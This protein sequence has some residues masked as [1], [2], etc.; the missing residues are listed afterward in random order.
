M[1]SRL[2]GG[3]GQSGAVL[4]L[5]KSGREPTGR[6]LTNAKAGGE[7]SE[8]RAGQQLGGR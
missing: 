3:H 7:G 4:E 2:G 1:A 5:G 6:K 8:V